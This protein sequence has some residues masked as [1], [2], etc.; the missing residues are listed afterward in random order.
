MKYITHLTLS[1]HMHILNQVN[2]PR[3]VLRTKHVILNILPPSNINHM[4]FSH[5]QPR[6]LFSYA[7]Y[8]ICL[9]PLLL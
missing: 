4:T 3:H 5:N 9:F 2:N 1:Q 7:N 8:W 6:N